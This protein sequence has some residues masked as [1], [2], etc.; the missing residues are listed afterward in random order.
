MP[1]HRHRKRITGPTLVL[2]GGASLGAVQ[3]G[4][5]CTFL[6]SGFQPSVIVGT[7]VG[8]LN[9]AFLAFHPGAAGGDKLVEIWA[10]LHGARIF[11]FNPL[12]MAYRLATK[13]QCLFSSRFLE[14]LVAEHLP[15]DDFAQTR[16][17]L[18]VTATN[19]SRGHKVVFHQGPISRAVLAST[20][21]PG[22][23]SPVEIEGDEYVDG[24]VMAHL[25]LETAV[26]L[27]AQQILAID[28][29]H[30]SDQ[31]RPTSPVGVLV[32]SLELMMR[33]HVDRDVEG[34]SPRARITLIRPEIGTDV[35]FA[36]LSHVDKLLEQ[37]EAMGQELLPSCTDAR[38]RLRPG[39]F[40]RPISSLG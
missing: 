34:L 12:G 27:G 37:G 19:L 20:A 18:Y 23:F 40:S 25:D 13:R 29:S 33:D 6:R 8:A 26:E 22:I 9:G 21:I 35:S 16:V 15:V 4:L 7:S 39:I 3:A 10:S 24:S 36:D 14:K 2:S 31:A 38:G 32:R 11:D 28:P 30:C 1:F 5:L 17:P